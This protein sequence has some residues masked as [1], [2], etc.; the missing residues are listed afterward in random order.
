MAIPPENFAI[1]REWPRLANAYR[2]G[3]GS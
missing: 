3:D 2:I 1:I